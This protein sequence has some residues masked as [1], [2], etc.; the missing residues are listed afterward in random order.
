MMTTQAEIRSIKVEETLPLRREMLRPD[1]PVQESVYAGDGDAPTQ[2]WG[3]FVGDALIAIASLYRESLPESIINEPNQ[4][5][6][7]ADNE[8]ARAIEQAWRLRGMAVDSAFQGKGYGRQLL[9]R[10]L[11]SVADHDGSLLWCNAR[12]TAVGFYQVMAFQTAG[13]E[14]EI[15]G[16]GPHFVML[17]PVFP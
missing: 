3:A 5:V 16:V 4:G 17:C 15:P 8:Q 11:Q 13:S 10:C 9:N 6:Q 12:T 1:R 7:V 2:H 14:F